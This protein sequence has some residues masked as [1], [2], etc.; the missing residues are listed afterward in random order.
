MC[1]LFGLITPFYI[2]LLKFFLIASWSVFCIPHFYAMKSCL[3]SGTRLNV[4][5]WNSK[6]VAMRQDLKVRSMSATGENG[7]YK[8]PTDYDY[9]LVAIGAGSGGVRAARFAAQFGAKVAICEMPFAP[10]SSD[11]AGGVGGT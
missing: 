11:E 8:E 5:P 1:R 2:P 4:R 3:F 10:I 6:A 9:D 7:S